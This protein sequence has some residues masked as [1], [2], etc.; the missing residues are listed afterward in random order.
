M[1]ICIDAGHGGKDPGAVGVRLKE[2]DVVLDLSKR[3]GELLFDHDVTQTRTSDTFLTLADRVG[4]A[5]DCELFVSLHCNGFNDP[6]AN[7]TETLYNARSTKGKRYAMVI[8]DRLI[9]ATERTNRGI[10]PRTDLYV[11]RH[12]PMP[13]VLVEVAFIT[14]PE[15]EY[16]LGLD[17]F[18]QA[19]AV[20][21]S[22]GIK[23]AIEWQE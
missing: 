17:G 23:E 14:N 5:S 4:I 8:Q 22:K 1:K 15:E 7:G 18:L 9:D 21:I 6:Q 13:A 10:K 20:G 19:A 11:L 16:L 3:V 2:S 12:T